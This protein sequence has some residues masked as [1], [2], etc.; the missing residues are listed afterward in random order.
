[1][2]VETVLSKLR[3]ADPGLPCEEGNAVD[4]QYGESGGHLLTRITVMPHMTK[5]MHW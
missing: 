4:K 3:E 5:G 2:P 1:M